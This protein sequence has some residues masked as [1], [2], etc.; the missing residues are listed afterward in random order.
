M[1]LA[2]TAFEFYR[3]LIKNYDFNKLTFQDFLQELEQDPVN[4]WI[5][6]WQGFYFLSGYE[7]LARDRIK[8]QKNSIIKIRKLSRIAKWLE[9]IPFVRGVFVTGTLANRNA[10]VKSDWD[11]LLVMAKN[12]IWIGRLFVT[13]F[14]QLSGRRRK[15][16]KVC[17]RFC[18]NHYLTENNLIFEERNKFSAHFVATSFPLIGKELHN[19]M[20]QLNSHWIKELQPNFN[21]GQF[22]EFQNRESGWKSKVQFFI[23]KVLESMGFAGVINR[24]SK[25]LMIIKINKNKKTYF[26]KADIRYSDGALIFL[27]KPHRYK[28]EKNAQK[29]IEKLKPITT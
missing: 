24:V 3:F 20:L 26:E 23:E 11:L 29:I 9:L 22:F 5:T 19:K 15:D 8:K 10:Q 2:P 28:F 16:S 14:F 25:K 21:K 17:D 1:K 18:L 27:P 4:K 7:Q 13:I 6:N 12:R